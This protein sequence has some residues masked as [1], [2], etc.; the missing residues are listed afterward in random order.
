M[1]TGLI[2]RETQLAV[3]SQAGTLIECHG[4]NP[5]VRLNHLGLKVL[6]RLKE[7]SPIAT[8]VRPCTSIHHDN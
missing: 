4:V 6:L 1:I 2:P 3:L 5:K 8:L 7:S